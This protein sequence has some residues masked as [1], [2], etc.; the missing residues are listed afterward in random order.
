MLPIH[1]LVTFLISPLGTA[2]ALGALGLVLGL[3]RQR[4]LGASLGTFALVWL[5]LWATPWVSHQFRAQLEQPFAPVPPSQVQAA[6]AAVVLGGGI[7]PARRGRSALPDLRNAAD[8]VWHAARLYHAGK[9]PLLVLSGGS[10]TGTYATSEA[11]AMQQL[12]LQ[13]GV[14]EAAMLLEEASRNTQQNAQDCARL[15]RE[16]GI[17]RVLLVTSALHMQRALALFEAEGLQITAVA[18]DHEADDTSRWPWWRRWLPTG[19]A[20]EGSGRAFKEWVG[21]RV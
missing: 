3:A 13:M 15:L 14:P 6:P 2:I 7:E 18:A 5:W 20:L 10:D 19:D 11:M 12:L 4:R 1:A 21:H 9:A 17:Q 8:R 16:R